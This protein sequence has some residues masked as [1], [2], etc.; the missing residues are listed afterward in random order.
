MWSRVSVKNCE[1]HKDLNP[2]WVCKLNPLKVENWSLNWKANRCTHSKELSGS[3]WELH[4][5]ISYELAT[6]FL[7]TNSREPEESLDISVQQGHIHT[8]IL[9]EVFFIMVEKRVKAKCLSTGKLTN[10]NVFRQQ[11]ATQLWQYGLGNKSQHG[12]VSQAWYG[13]LGGGSWKGE[14]ILSQNIQSIIALTKTLR[15]AGER[16]SH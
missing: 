13:R 6:L 7:E 2:S 5:R 14:G 9:V 1:H 12:W 10:H 11:N 8:S 16:L 15:E 3:V 4:K